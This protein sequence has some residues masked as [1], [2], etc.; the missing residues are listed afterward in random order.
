MTYA[1]FR[2]DPSKVRVSIARDG[3]AWRATIATRA[4]D[5]LVSRHGT[6]PRK[7]LARALRAADE[8]RMPGIDLGM[9]WA[10]HHPHHRAPAR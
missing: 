8:A 1:R 9:D 5:A 7:A 6:T 10:Y 3:T 2:A 4:D